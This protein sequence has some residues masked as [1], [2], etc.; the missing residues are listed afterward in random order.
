MFIVFSKLSCLVNFHNEKKIVYFFKCLFIGIKS[1]LNKEEFNIRFVRLMRSFRVTNV[2][3]KY[4][5]NGS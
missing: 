3:L 2:F 1:L 5:L 4:L